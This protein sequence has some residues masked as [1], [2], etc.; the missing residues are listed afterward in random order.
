MIKCPLCNGEGQ[1]WDRFNHFI[2]RTC[3][4]CNGEGTMPYKIEGTSVMV[5]RNGK[6]VLLKRHRTVKEAQAHLSALNINAH[7]K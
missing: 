5:L 1:W 4:F 7:K 2:L 6:W 3:L